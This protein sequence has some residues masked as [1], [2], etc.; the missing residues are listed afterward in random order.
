MSKYDRLKKESDRVFA[1]TEKVTGQRNS[2]SDELMRVSNV[3]KNAGSIISDLDKQFSELTKLN[4]IDISLLFLATALQCARQYLFSNEKYR[5]QHD[6]G[7]KLMSNFVPKKWEDILLASV[8]YDAVRMGSDLKSEIGGIGIG[9]YTHR[10]RTLGHD[11]IL[12]WVF[13]TVNILSD[14]L[15]KTDVISTYQVRIPYITGRFPGGTSGAFKYAAQQA[16][17]NKLNMPAA[18]VR[19]AL[20]FGSDYF[21]KQGLPIPFLS[22]IN[23]NLSK[24][25]LTKYNI[26]MWSITRGATLSI[27][28]N[29]LISFIHR[30]FYNETEDGKSRLYEVRTR[31]ILSYSNTIATGSNIIYVALSKDLK[32]LDVGGMLVTLYRLIMD[33][34]FIQKVKL[35]FI[36]EK[37]NE[38]VI[39][40]NI[41]L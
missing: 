1:A 36:S 15:T 40:N 24:D 37:W 11:P 32:K 35:E 30:L 9:G 12:G 7:D 14:S 23:N 4:G 17:A 25:F 28:I 29:T 22:T 20:H 41:E 2:I 18:V 5:L 26:D 19:Q 21:T 8:P 33:Y 6:D 13:G 31:K 38:L 10:Y 3:V 39:G 27:L 16:G 34:N